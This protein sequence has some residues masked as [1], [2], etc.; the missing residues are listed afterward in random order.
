MS[1]MKYFAAVCHREPR[2]LGSRYGSE[3][4]WACIGRA[5]G[6]LPM[7]DGVDAPLSKVGV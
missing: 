4:E 3:K 7:Q 2:E 6:I 1:G 5:E